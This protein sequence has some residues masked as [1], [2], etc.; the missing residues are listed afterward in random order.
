MKRFFF[1]VFLVLFLSSSALALVENQQM[2][3]LAVT[4][5]GKGLGADLFLE[6]EPGTGKVWVLAEPLVGTTTQ[7]AAQTAV[8]VAKTYSSEVSKHDY[9]FAIQS[10]ASVVEGPSAGAAMA[11]LVIAAFEDKQ[12]PQ[13]VAMTG[14][15]DESGA[16]GPV[17]GVFEK[18]KEAASL[19][20]DLFMIPKGEALQTVR[21]DGLVKSVNLVEYGPKELGMTIIEVSTIDEALKYAFSDIKSIDIE[22]IISESQVP[23]FIPKQISYDSHLQAMKDLT[24]SYVEETKVIIG[25]ARN[26]ASSTL[27]N[28]SSV[29]STLLEVIN[30]SENLVKDADNL[31]TQNYLY[32]AANFAFL[33]RV[34]ALLAKDISN[35]PSLLSINSSTLEIKINELRNQINDFE[36][37]LDSDIPV[38]SLEWFVSAQQRLSYAKLNLQKLSSTQTIIIGGS[39]SRQVALKR[40]SD[41][42]FSVAWLDVA[43][44]FYSIAKNSK[45][46]AKKDTKFK[47][48]A[49]RLVTEAENKVSLLPESESLED[50]NRRLDAAKL[51]LSKGW[52]VAAVVDASTAKALAEAEVLAKDKSLEELSSVLK[53]KISSLESKINDSKHVFSWPLL[54]VDHSKYFLE[55]ANYYTLQGESSRA[56]SSLRSGV[57][58][59]SLAQE[60]F[61]SLEEVYTQYDSADTFVPDRLFFPEVPQ[62]TSDSGSD[63]LVSRILMPAFLVLIFVL[64]FVFMFFTVKT[65]SGT[66]STPVSYR[67]EFLKLKNLR[68]KADEALFAGSISEEKHSTIVDSY[69]KELDRLEKLRELKARELVEME[70]LSQSIVLLDKKMEGLKQDLKKDVVLEEEFIRQ[71][72]L[73]KKELGGLTRR[74]EKTGNGKEEPESQVHKIAFHATGGA[75]KK[76]N[77]PK[78]SEKTKT[79]NEGK[80]E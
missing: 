77:S 11:L 72:S 55:S 79:K 80:K 71:K 54:Y 66:D 29:I 63:N 27:I 57:S 35:N 24:N 30:S 12:V 47:D 64:A 65:I 8:N 4:N 45:K 56:A 44:D 62:T 34:N 68:A 52:F 40:V 78:A 48:L 39:E 9:K 25:E 46:A 38:D 28:D 73:L 42:E 23:D 70:E 14:T 17:G 50:I 22:K 13:N 21:E 3:V 59:I 16:V 61:S 26:A 37:I 1:A 10:T 60:I 75:K 7:S 36:E 19:G 53:E 58:L 69:S 51:E 76:K 49:Q 74:I 41:Y 5:E 18:S 6:V 2:K 15:I 33:A 31:N 32:S 20:I 43:K 67:K